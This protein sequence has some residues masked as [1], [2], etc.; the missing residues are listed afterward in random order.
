[1]TKTYN[2]RINHTSKNVDTEGWV[3]CVDLEFGCSQ[4]MISDGDKWMIGW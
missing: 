3:I 4:I 2:N 1:M